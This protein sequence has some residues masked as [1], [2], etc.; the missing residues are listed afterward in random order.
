LVALTA[1]LIVNRRRVLPAA[2]LVGCG[3]LPFVIYDLAFF[4]TVLP[5]PVRAKAITY[6]LD[7][8][9]SLAT[10]VQELPFGEFGF[11]WIGCS[12][13][14]AVSFAIPLLRRPRT[15]ENLV[16]AGFPLSGVGVL[17]AYLAVHAYVFPWYLP[18]YF[19]PFIFAASCIFMRP[20]PPL[21]LLAVLTLIPAG[22]LL[23]G[24]ATAALGHQELSISSVTNARVNQYL[25][26]GESLRTTCPGCNL[27]TTEIGGLGYSFEGEIIDAE[28]L[29]SPAALA[30]H[31]LSVPD[32]RPSLTTGAIP[33]EFAEAAEPDL[34]VSYDIFARA[35]MRSDA[36][37]GYRAWRCP[38][39]T[40]KDESIRLQAP[41]W[42]INALWIWVADDLPQ[43]DEIGDRIEAH[44]RC[45]AA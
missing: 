27:L 7:L 28:G 30:F 39:F 42:G 21:V 19:I 25:E 36:L 44:N 3:F 22:V 4:G 35:L 38:V 45:R 16:V 5:Q 18:L 13:A 2:G 33:P 26:V 14:L 24:K 32:E 23:I 43:A 20:S 8:P 1:E 29:V 10:S 11:I 34:I 12:I 6:D 40:A 9:H 15:R 41:L 37:T 17:V 31:P